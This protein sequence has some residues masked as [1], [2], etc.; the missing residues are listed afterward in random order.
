[1]GDITGIFF[2]SRSSFPLSP[3]SRGSWISIPRCF[4]PLASIQPNLREDLLHGSSIL[5]AYD[6]NVPSSSQY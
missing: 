1:M 3:C 2:K 6:R 5:E 4:H